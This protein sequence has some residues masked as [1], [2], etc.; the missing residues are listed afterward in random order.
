MAETEMW[1]SRETTPTSSGS[2]DH[3]PNACARDRPDPLT[4]E[5]RDFAENVIGCAHQT[6]QIFKILRYKTK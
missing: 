3:T 2:G 5:A 1:F 6:V 4:D